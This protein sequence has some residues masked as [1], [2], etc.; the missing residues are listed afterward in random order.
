MSV[1]TTD[2]GRGGWSM[3]REP[4]PEAPSVV[5]EMECTT[6]GHASGPA[7]ERTAVEEWAV[8]H[9]V[10][11]PA[12]SGFREIVHRFWRALPTAPSDDEAA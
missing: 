7:E 12:H 2:G 8:R 9:A 5:F 10:G 11:Y 3:V 1:H 4:A 6:C